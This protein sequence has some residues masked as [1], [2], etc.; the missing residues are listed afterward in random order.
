MFSPVPWWVLARGGKGYCE[1]VFDLRK[2]KQHSPHNGIVSESQ[3]HSKK[4]LRK[5]D[6]KSSGVSVE[7]LSKNESQNPDELS[8]NEIPNLYKVIDLYVP[9]QTA[10]FRC[11]R[12]QSSSK[13]SK[14]SRF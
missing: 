10:I 11:Q 8:F 6:E 3:W 9:E 14:G 5:G 2:E 13:S 7:H 4:R 12:R 1:G